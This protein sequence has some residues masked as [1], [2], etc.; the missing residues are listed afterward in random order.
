MNKQGERKGGRQKGTPNRITTEKALQLIVDE[1]TEKL[2][3]RHRAGQP[4]TA[5]GGVGTVPLNTYVECV[6]ALETLRTNPER[7]QGSE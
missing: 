6:M 4:L 7:E 5:V 3:K 2:A 1:F